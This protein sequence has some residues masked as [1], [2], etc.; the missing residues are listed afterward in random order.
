MSNNKVAVPEEIIMNK[1][2]LIREQKVMLDRDLAELYGVLTGN[3][4]K[5]VKRNIK[6]F[7]EDFMFQLT[8]EEFDNLIFQFGTSS[9]KRMKFINIFL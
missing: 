7:P 1:I 8:K 2:Y 6:R 5:A 9:L 4:N 3:L